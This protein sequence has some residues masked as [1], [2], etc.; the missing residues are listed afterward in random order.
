MRDSVRL[1]EREIPVT[2]KHPAKSRKG[3]YRLSDNFFRFWFR[4]VLP[5]KSR[6][7]EGG[8]RKVMEEEILPH[9]DNF[10][11]QV[12][13]TIC[14]EILRYL[15]DEEKI[16]LSYDRAGRWWNG[17]EEIDLVAVAGDKPVFAAECKWSKKPVGIDILKDLCRKASLILSDETSDNLRLGLFSR[18]GFTK[19]IEALGRKD[20][21]ELIDVRKTGP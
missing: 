12:F 11:G 9:L 13:D 14:V 17:N 21:I 18:S 3:I 15:V 19:E 4:F 20:E 6:L 10:I 7:V 5:Y 8:E 16:E 2:E 1:I